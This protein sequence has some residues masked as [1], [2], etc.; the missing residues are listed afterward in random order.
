M[1]INCNPVTQAGDPAAN[2]C[3]SI[4]SLTAHR[5]VKTMPGTTPAY[6]RVEEM[7]FGVGDD[8]TWGKLLIISLGLMLLTHVAPARGIEKFTDSQGTLHITNLGPKKPDSPV[9][10]P[11]PG[12]SSFPGNLP[13]NIPVTPP[14][15]ELVPE[16]QV[17]EPE[18]QPEPEPGVVPNEPVPVD[19]QPGAGVTHTEGSGGVTQVAVRTGEKEGPRT[20]AEAPAAL[21]I[22]ICQ[23]TTIFL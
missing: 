6:V 13:G 2:T 5:S 15:R 8:M 18:T 4:C 11:S 22:P 12:T 16:A 1:P 10:P 3:V 20:A 9:D 7:L 17:P 19:P 21:L 14:A 23:Q